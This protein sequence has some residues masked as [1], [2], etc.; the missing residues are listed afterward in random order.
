MLQTMKIHK[1]VVNIQFPRFL[2]IDILNLFFVD[3]I[4]VSFHF[5]RIQILLH[6]SFQYLTASRS[7][8]GSYAPAQ[9]KS[10]ISN[11]IK[12]TKRTMILVF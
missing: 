11:L 8:A 4:Y 12:N 10:G 3:G 7:K 2:E 1:S 5:D 9:K 6:E